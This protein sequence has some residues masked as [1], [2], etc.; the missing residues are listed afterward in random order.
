[1][2]Y[3]GFR[4]LFVYVINGFEFERS[5]A[6]SNL[7]K[8]I[9][10]KSCLYFSFFKTLC[11]VIVINPFFGYLTLVIPR[12]RGGYRAEMIV[13]SFRGQNRSPRGV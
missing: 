8:L 6:A 13:V 1:M 7:A 5:E 2:L 12:K 10:S 3:T 11:C 4:L 9:Y